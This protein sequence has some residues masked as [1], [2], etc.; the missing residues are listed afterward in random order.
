MPSLTPA[1]VTLLRQHPH[2]MQLYLMIDTEGRYLL[3]PY[4][5]R[6]E[7][8]PV[9]EG[10]DEIAF[11]MD[12]FLVYVDQ[13]KNFGPV[14]IMGPPGAAFI[15]P[16]TGV[17][18]LTFNGSDSYG[19][20]TF[21]TNYQWLFVDGTPPLHVG[22][23]PVTVTWDTAGVYRVSLTVADGNGE[24]RTGCRLIYVLDYDEVAEA[25]WPYRDWTL[26]SLSGS[27]GSSHWKARFSIRPPAGAS[28]DD[29][30]AEGQCIIFAD[31]IRY[32]GDGPPVGQ[33]G[34]GGNFFNRENVLFVGYLNKC[35]TSWDSEVEEVT[36]EAE[37]V[38]GQMK[39]VDNY[40]FVYQ[41]S[42]TDDPVDWDEMYWPTPR[43]ILW[44]LFTYFSNLIEITD[45]HL[46]RTPVDE[47]AGGLGYVKYQDIPEGSLHGQGMALMESVRNGVIASDRQGS[48]YC[49]ADLQCLPSAEH[50]LVP[51]IMDITQD[52]W[53]GTVELAEEPSGVSQVY[54]DGMAYDPSQHGV[55]ELGGVIP[56]AAKAPG[57]PTVAGTIEEYEGLILVDQDDLNSIAG[58]LYEMLSDRFKKCKFS[59]LGAYA[60][61]DIVP[62]EYFALTLPATP[63]VRL[64]SWDEDTRLIPRAV[65][66]NFNP[67][68]G[69]LQVTI[70]EAERET[71]DSVGVAADLDT[72]AYRSGA[73]GYFA[74]EW[75]YIFRYD[76]E[77]L[78]EY[79][80]CGGPGGSLCW[81]CTPGGFTHTTFAEDVVALLLN[82]DGTYLYAICT[83]TVYRYDLSQWEDYTGPAPVAW[84][85]DLT[86]PSWTDIRC[87][88]MSHN[89]TMLIIV[90]PAWIHI[91][92][93]ATFTNPIDWWVGMAPP[94]YHDPEC[95]F[96]GLADEQLYIGFDSHGD[97]S[98]IPPF[99]AKYSIAEIKEMMPAGFV[100]TYLWEEQEGK[101][102]TVVVS[103]FMSHDGRYG[104]FCT[105]GYYNRIVRVKLEGLSVHG[106][107]DL[108]HTGE[109]C[110]RGL[111]DSYAHG[112]V[113]SAGRFPKI[114]KVDLGDL[115]VEG[116]L[117]SLTGELP[118]Q[119]RTLENYQRPALAMS[120]DGK[121]LYMGGGNL[122]AAVNA[123]VVRVDP[124]DFVAQDYLEPPG[125]WIGRFQTGVVTP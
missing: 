69:D 6:I 122:F 5:Y 97:T 121:H 60:V 88:C 33:L 25:A 37:G 27:L 84:P 63:P 8:K 113:A 44:S 77:P 110:V 120:P 61:F 104:Y 91:I 99:V 87:A 105:G 81:V 70:T 40:S 102:Q 65:S 56:L 10:G 75:G 89:G 124:K 71:E 72:G 39:R 35:D 17:A 15:D 55:G 106:A 74:T 19:V 45:V 92:D 1:E 83:T 48:V 108:P 96:I 59:T 57:T 51:E 23:G 24:V 76:L 119:Y 28:P 7:T 21:I 80:D 29:F 109:A 41:S 32:G 116:T 31:Q 67:A 34:I 112:Y 14:P 115:A 100:R 43:R 68:A 49:E 47:G 73:Y 79:K 101:E 103:C 58:G 42:G 66:M 93:L 13:H 54:A 36:Y 52:D 38:C 98:G 94:S 114:S 3:E 118:F 16:D 2:T 22:A 53:Y 78:A 125:M 107:G 90:Q 95:C 64:A 82:P 85:D 30:P 4:Y 26:E 18:S 50:V 20:G 62:Q 9:E 111:G 117:H 86:S 46:L 11:Y 12:E 123:R